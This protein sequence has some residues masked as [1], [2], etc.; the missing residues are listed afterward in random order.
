ML[1]NLLSKVFHNRSTTMIATGINSISL[2]P[3]SIRDMNKPFVFPA[4]VCQLSEIGPVDRAVW[5]TAT[6]ASVDDIRI[7]GSRAITNVEIRAAGMN[8]TVPEAIMEAA[9]HRE[10]TG[11]RY[12]VFEHPIHKYLKGGLHSIVLEN[13]MVAE[14]EDKVLV[15]SLIPRDGV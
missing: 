6:I 3:H 8:L 12:I 10:V 1:A 2:L 4:T 13:T 11:C 15:I 5:L 7:E 9:R 14:S